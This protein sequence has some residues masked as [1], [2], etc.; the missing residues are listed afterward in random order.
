MMSVLTCYCLL[1]GLFFFTTF[2]LT[3][4][5]SQVESFNSLVFIHLTHTGGSSISNIFF[6]ICEKSKNLQC[7]D[8]YSSKSLHSIQFV[9]NNSLD[10][11]HGHFEFIPEQVRR[12]MKGKALIFTIVRDYYEVLRSSYFYLKKTESSSTYIRNTNSDGISNRLG[13]IDKHDIKVSNV[14]YQLHHED[15]RPAIDYIDDINILIPYPFIFTG[16]Q[17]VLN[18]IQSLIGNDN[19]SKGIYMLCFNKVNIIT[20]H[21]TNE[22]ELFDKNITKYDHIHIDLVSFCAKQIIKIVNKRWE[23]IITSSDYI[24]N[25]TTKLIKTSCSEIKHI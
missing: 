24:N 4:T 22:I 15:C 13:G 20:S 7:L 3:E 17:I 25:V 11:L 12:V 1:F 16:F 8:T 9:Q 6:E 21:K 18:T 5:I 19:V 23:T 10:I 14:P 2:F